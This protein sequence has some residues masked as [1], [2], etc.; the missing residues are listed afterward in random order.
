MIRSWVEDDIARAGQKAFAR[1]LQQP[2]VA[3]AHQVGGLAV[4]VDII[5]RVDA[6]RDAV[7]QGGLADLFTGLIRNANA[8]H[9]GDLQVM[10]AQ[11]PDVLNGGGRAGPGSGLRA[12]DRSKTDGLGG[13]SHH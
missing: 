2:L 5:G 13:V 3:L 6:Q 1:R 4:E 9:P 8:L 7:L 10:H 11:Q 12:A